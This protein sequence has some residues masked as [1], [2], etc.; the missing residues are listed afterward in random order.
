MANNNTPR[1]AILNDKGYIIERLD[2]A[3]TAAKHANAKADTFYKVYYVHDTV[4]GTTK[5]Y[6]GFHTTNTRLS[7]FNYYCYVMKQYNN[8]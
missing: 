8:K 2:D 6:H 5:A 1:Y 7:R 3:Y 4:K